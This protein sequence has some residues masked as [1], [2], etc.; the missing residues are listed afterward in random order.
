[1]DLKPKL[2]VAWRGRI[3][4]LPHHG[5]PTTGV[6]APRVGTDIDP[7]WFRVNTERP[8]D[9]IAVLRP[10]GFRRMVQGKSERVRAVRI[11]GWRVGNA[12]Q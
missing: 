8:T 12:I 2:G 11:D 7:A 1:V 6:V 5:W 10:N 9:A 4:S 3:A